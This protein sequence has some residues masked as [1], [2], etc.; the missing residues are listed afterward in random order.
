MYRAG[1]VKGSSRVLWLWCEKIVFTAPVAGKKW[2]CSPHIHETWEEPFSPALRGGITLTY[3][4]IWSHTHHIISRLVQ[5]SCRSSFNVF[6]VYPFTFLYAFIKS[7]FS[8]G[9]K[10]I[11][12]KLLFI[13]YRA[14]PPWMAW[15]RGPGNCDKLGESLVSF[16]LLPRL[17]LWDSKVIT[18]SGSKHHENSSYTGLVNNT[19]KLLEE[20]YRRVE[21][22]KI[23]CSRNKLHQTI[24]YKYHFPVH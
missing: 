4:R 8:P 12:P 17:L 6:L 3:C 9:S 24:W 5:P 23:G 19:W 13:D 22:E 18:E 15:G 7:S 10:S 21:A 16:V 1:L 2:N 11:I 14:G 20:C